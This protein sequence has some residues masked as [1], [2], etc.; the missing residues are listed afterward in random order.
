MGK[1]VEIKTKETKASVKDFINS[2]SGDQK[3][4]DSFTILK[5][6]E[7]VTKEKPKMWGSSIIGFG[8]LIY[9]SP[10]TGRQVEW[11][12]IGFS[13]RKANITIYL[14][15]MKKHS[16][17]L[18][19]LGKHKIGGGCLYINKLED[20]DTKVLEKMISVAAKK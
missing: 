8:N 19:K 14:M 6:M 12:K 3:I 20:I 2:V 16:E 17:A 4:K 18:K 11:F 5:M 10:S 15:D 13:P 9:Q 7:K 1:L